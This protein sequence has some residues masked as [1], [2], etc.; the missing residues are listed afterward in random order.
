LFPDRKEGQ[1]CVVFNHKAYVQLAFTQGT[2]LQD[3]KVILKG[4]GGFGKHLNFKQLDEF[5]PETVLGFVK[6]AAKLST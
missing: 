5:D 6:A 1:F 2:Q 3:P 4:S